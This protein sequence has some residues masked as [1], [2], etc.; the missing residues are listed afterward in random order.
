MI[1]WGGQRQQMMCIFYGE[2]RT[3]SQNRWGFQIVSGNYSMFIS[4][5]I[6]K[7]GFNTD[8]V[9]NEPK[10]W[11]LITVLD[12]GQLVSGSRKC[13]VNGVLVNSSSVAPSLPSFFNGN[14]NESWYI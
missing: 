2:V 7:G 4:D 9:S 6:D 10:E 11:N 14:T 3:S 1:H 5:S 13:Y 8:R 12:E